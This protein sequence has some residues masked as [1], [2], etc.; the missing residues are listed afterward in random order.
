M[1]VTL[2]RGE[3]RKDP[4]EAKFIADY[5]ADAVE[6]LE[7]VTEVLGRAYQE[8][9]ENLHHHGVTYCDAGN[10][11][12]ILAL[13]DQFKPYAVERVEQHAREVAIDEW[14]S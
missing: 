7:L 3:S 13:L 6:D 11:R 12:D 4:R 8:L 5:V 9:I 1:S 10:G 14:N 2:P